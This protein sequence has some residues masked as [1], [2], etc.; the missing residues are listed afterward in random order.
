M[1]RFSLSRKNGLLALITSF[2]LLLSLL[3]VHSTPSLAKPY[4]GAS[5]E[6]VAQHFYSWYLGAHFPTPNR[7]NTVTF[8][9]YVTQGFLKRATA[10]DVDAAT[11]RS[12]LPAQSA[13]NRAPK[14]SV[15]TSARS[16]ATSSADASVR[17]R[18]VCQRID[19]S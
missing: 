8:R 6:E 14:P 1:F 13:S 4:K 18:S 11:P 5:P 10:R 16:S 9:K 15:A 17:S 2:A 19:G 3:L 7:S 12:V